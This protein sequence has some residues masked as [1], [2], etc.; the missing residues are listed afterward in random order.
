MAYETEEVPAEAEGR[1]RQQY[2]HYYGHQN[3][4]QQ[5]EEKARECHCWVTEVRHSSTASGLGC[6][7]RSHLPSGQ[8]MKHCEYSDHA[9]QGKENANHDLPLI[10]IANETE[11]RVDEEYEP[12]DE[13]QQSQDKKD[14][15]VPFVS[16]APPI[17]Q[18]SGQQPAANPAT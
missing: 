8:H 3:G 10:A 9:Y 7:Y 1:N 11:Y 18:R 15:R 6:M 4:E 16:K 5:A 14:Q 2:Q 13:G 12:G 17:E